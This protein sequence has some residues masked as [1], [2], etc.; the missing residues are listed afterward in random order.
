M[1]VRFTAFMKISIPKDGDSE[2]IRDLEFERDRAFYRLLLSIMLPAALQQA[3]NIGVNLMDT[4]MLGSFGEV[5]ISGSNLANQFYNLFL[6]FCLGISGGCGV[7]SSQYWGKQDFDRVYSI[8]NMALRL[9]SVLSILFGVVTWLF[10]QQILHI[11]T[12]DLDTIREG[13]K[14]LRYTSFTYFFHGT[15]F[16]ACHLMRTV[17]LAKLGLIV[18]CVSFSV[19]LLANYMLIFGKFGAPRMEIAGAAVGTLISRIAEFGVTFF[20]IFSHDKKLALR[21]RHI[22]SPIPRE[23]LQKYFKI[24]IPVLF[25]DLLLSFGSQIISIILGH[26]GVAVVASNSICQVVDRI[27][28][29]I[30][31]GIS[32]AA[33]VIIGNVIGQGD[34]KAALR[35]GKTINYLGIAFGTVAAVIVWLLGPWTI[36]FYNLDPATVIVATKMMRAYSLIIFFQSTQ[37]VLT[38]GVLR[39]G[40]DTKFLLLS[41]TVFMWLVSIPLGILGGLIFNWPAWLVMLCVR[42][43]FI[44]KTLWCGFRLY[45]G[46]WINNVSSVANC[47]A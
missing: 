30:I 47:N 17:G 33:A 3:I 36:S 19:N 44:I 8:F 29:V 2:I 37:S 1:D 21:F 9:V 25:S 20:Y 28:T 7:L 46:K 45:S 39:G 18:S 35:Q 23:L 13:A 27:S 26:M 11:Y 43:D 16:I 24:G 41:D 4:I 42:F 38:K 22:L 6:F 5:Q 40:G 10:P 31:Y 34:H 14:Y 32:N 12:N 15:G